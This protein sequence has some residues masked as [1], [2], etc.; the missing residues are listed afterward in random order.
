MCRSRMASI[1]I[2]LAVGAEVELGPV[3]TKSKHPLRP[4]C[5]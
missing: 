1:S 5:K 2:M 3:L 4:H